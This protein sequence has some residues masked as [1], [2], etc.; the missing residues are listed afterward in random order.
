MMQHMFPS[1]RITLHDY[2]NYVFSD[3]S[4]NEFELEDCAKRH[5]I[6]AK[7]IFDY[8]SYCDTGI[9]VFTNAPSRW[10]LGTGFDVDTD[11]VSPE[12][13]LT[14]LKPWAAAYNRIET[15]YDDNL[16]VFVDDNSTNFTVP[17]QRPDRWRCVLFEGRLH[18]PQT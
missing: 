17:R 14:L 12:D 2:N 16:F 1:E 7:S 13:D 8:A 3:E 18:G 9:S 10:V 11:I 4:L 5:M 15:L 6:K